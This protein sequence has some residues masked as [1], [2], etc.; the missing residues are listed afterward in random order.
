MIDKAERIKELAIKGLLTDDGH[1]KQWYI[2]KILEEIG[3]DIK[4]IW[5]ELK[6]E[7]YDWDEG[8]PP[9][10]YMEKYLY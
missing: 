7:D 3:Y 9:W 1:H 4:E 8:I 2:E 5:E 10:T 6:N